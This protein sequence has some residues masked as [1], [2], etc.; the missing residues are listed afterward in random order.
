MVVTTAARRQQSLPIGQSPSIGE[1]YPEFDER[2]GDGFPRANRSVARLVGRRMYQIR[3]GYAGIQ[4]ELGDDFEFE[5]CI[6]TR[7]VL[8][9]AGE[10]WVGEPL[11]AEATSMLLPLLGDCVES[12][13][14]GPDAALHLTVGGVDIDVWPHEFYESWQLREPNGAL[15]V[16]PSGGESISFFGPFPPP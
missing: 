1:V 9:R 15:T 4:L 5:V 11:T 8:T 7:L 14:V 10:P 6:D 13:S 2:R 16:C 12:A 3:L